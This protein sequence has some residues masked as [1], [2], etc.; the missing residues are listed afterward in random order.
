MTVRTKKTMLLDPQMSAAVLQL[1]R[2]LASAGAKLAALADALSA[3]STL[4]SP[5]LQNPYVDQNVDLRP[6]GLPTV[7][8]L[9]VDTNR[10]LAVPLETTHPSA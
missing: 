4:Q 9:Y 7:Q 3:N 6:S 10:S 2:G 5:T 8:N 1:F